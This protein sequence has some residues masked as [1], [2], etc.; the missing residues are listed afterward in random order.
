MHVIS[1]ETLRVEA[2]LVWPASVA[3]IRVASRLTTY[4]AHTMQDGMF[5]RWDDRLVAQVVRDT[6]Q[7]I[8]PTVVSLSLAQAALRH[9]CIRLAAGQ[10]GLWVMSQV[11][12]FDAHGVS[13]HANHRAVHRGLL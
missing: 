11:I 3:A 8:A 10:R 9:L 13:G 7:A 5:T 2:L 4:T 6:T 1:K 12:T